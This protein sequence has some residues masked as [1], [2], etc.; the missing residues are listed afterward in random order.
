MIK[1]K[2]KKAAPPRCVVTPEDAFWIGLA[3]QV[4]RD[5][6]AE[7][8]RKH[9]RGRVRKVLVAHGINPDRAWSESLDK[10]G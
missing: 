5:T 2:T 10:R 8:V 7:F 9:F 3:A 1:T 4:T 6:Q